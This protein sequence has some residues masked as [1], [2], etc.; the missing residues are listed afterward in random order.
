MLERQ[1]QGINMHDGKL[2]SHDEVQAFETYDDVSPIIVSRKPSSGAA[3]FE[4]FWPLARP[5]V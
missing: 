5:H 3:T 2:I 1:V 4:R